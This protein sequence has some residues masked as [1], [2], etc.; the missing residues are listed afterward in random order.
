MDTGS[1]EVPEL[2]LFTCDLRV[3]NILSFTYINDA[4][5]HQLCLRMV[6]LGAS[7][8]D[9]LHTVRADA[10]NYEGNCLTVMLTMLN[11]QSVFP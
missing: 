4:K 7:A 11:M 8:K 2:H 1:A 6:S 9:K 5:E 10:M 3:T